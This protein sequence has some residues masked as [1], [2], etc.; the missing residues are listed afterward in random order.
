M[1]ENPIFITGVYRSG[2]TL[3]TSILAAHKELDI[4]HP[5]VQYFRYIVKKNIGPENYKDIVHSISERVLK[6][7]SI[8]LDDESLVNEV[9]M[10]QRINHHVIYDVVMR[11]IYGNSGKRWG[12]KSLLEWTSIPTFLSMYPKGKAIH[13]LRDPRD[14]LA[15]YKNMTYETKDKYIDAVF[16]CLDSFKSAISYSATFS[17][18]RYC[19]VRYEDLVLDKENEIK[20]ICNFLEVDFGDY[21]LSNENH[22]EGMGTGVVQLTTDT[23]SSFPDDASNPTKRWEKKLSADELDFAEALLAPVMKNFN[24][25][26]S[27]GYKDNGIKWLLDLVNGTELIKDRLVQYLQTGEGV[28]SFPSD[29]TKEEN[30]STSSAAQGKVTGKGAAAAYQKMNP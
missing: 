27:D 19:A 4:G 6:R 11:A 1:I 26:L 12:E 10:A 9:E 16:N 13:I 20:R 22:V 5:S 29:P 17:D 14:V 18:D 25:E 24:Y 30:W 23:H 7:Y 28:E 21:I 8:K 15:S 2:T 3:L